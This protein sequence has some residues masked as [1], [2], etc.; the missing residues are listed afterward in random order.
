[1]SINHKLK[2]SGYRVFHPDRSFTLCERFVSGWRKFGP[3]VV[4][5]SGRWWS[6]KN[7]KRA[8]KPTG[9]Q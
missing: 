2:P 8:P 4:L 5:P 3:F 6:K 7:L 1:M 9:Q